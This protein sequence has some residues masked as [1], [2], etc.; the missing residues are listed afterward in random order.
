MSNLQFEHAQ[1]INESSDYI[2]LSEES[3]I[4]IKKWVNKLKEI[5]ENKPNYSQEVQK[6]IDKYHSDLDKIIGVLS[7][8][9]GEITKREIT[10]LVAPIISVIGG[11]GISAAL[12]GADMPVIIGI[13]VGVVY[14]IVMG[15]IIYFRKKADKEAL[16]NLTRIKDAL[17]KVNS[18]N[19]N[20]ASKKKIKKCINDI[21]NCEDDFDHLDN[22]IFNTSNKSTTI[23][24]TT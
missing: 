11:I 19:L 13:I 6:F 8:E 3:L 5:K 22:S 4:P 9:K 21:E 16:K 20:D 15:F 1:F 10:T 23:I 18:N 17:M 2:V 24:Y 7:K 14:D 12:G